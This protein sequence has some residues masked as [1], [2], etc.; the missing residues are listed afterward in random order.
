MELRDQGC[1]DWRRKDQGGIQKESQG[2]KV[3]RR[4]QATTAKAVRTYR[5]SSTI[6]E[7]A[8]ECALVALKR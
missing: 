6:Y 1:E 3:E 4:K 8:R 2:P 5:F 7:E